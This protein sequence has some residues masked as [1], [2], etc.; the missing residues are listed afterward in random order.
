MDNNQEMLIRIDEKL[1][2]LNTLVTSN[3][4]RS[5]KEIKELWEEIE[6]LRVKINTLVEMNIENSFSA[7]IGRTILFL[8][9][10]V[11]LGVLINKIFNG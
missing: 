10:S 9:S 3:N 1:T 8:V 2:A 5:A 4:D 7:K 11:G 6:A